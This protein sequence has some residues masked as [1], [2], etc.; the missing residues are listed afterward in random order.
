M[1][2]FSIIIPAYN[3]EK[4]IARTL[5]SI[6]SQ[7]NGGIEVIVVND[8]STDQTAMVT[9]SVLAGSRIANTSVF[10]KENGGVSSARN[11]GFDKAKGEYVFFLDGD[12]Y[13]ADGFVGSVMELLE[14]CKPQVVHW[15]Y[16]LV[17]E[18]GSVLNEYPYNTEGIVTKTGAETLSAILL[19]RSTRI[20]T[21][22]I[23]YNRKFLEENQ[24]RFTPGCAV[25]EDLEFIFLALSYAQSVLSTNRI[26]SNYLQRPA[27][28]MSTHSIRKFDAILALGRVRDHFLR[29]KDPEYAYL[30]K[31]F[32]DYEIL[33]Y[34]AGTFR[35]CLQHLVNGEK[36]RAS[37]AIKQLYEE[38]ENLYPGMNEEIAHKMRNRWKK[39]LPDRID[40]FRFSP[41]LYLYL[42]RFTDE[43]Q[44]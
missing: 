18:K 12:D 1:I 23:A 7:N 22:S 27:S 13:V 39:G 2:K 17:N 42:S 15:P 31:H 38:I 21:G 3:V 6:L 33:H 35:L 20:W 25:G 24:I 37:A 4:Y 10:T 8:G 16:D 36:K 26:K 43:K 41:L 28:V 9:A 40:V 19:E 32:N 5:L 44:S 11:Y 30:A 14:K 34:Y 29:L